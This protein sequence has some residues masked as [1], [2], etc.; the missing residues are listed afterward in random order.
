[1]EDMKKKGIKI[2]SAYTAIFTT[3]GFY[4]GVGC[5]VIVGL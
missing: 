3:P 5:K 2:P 1:M 4:L